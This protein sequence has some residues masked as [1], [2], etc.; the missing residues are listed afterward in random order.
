MRAKL[1]RSAREADIDVTMLKNI[2]V[3]HPV[4][5]P[6]FAIAESPVPNSETLWNAK[7]PRC[8]VSTLKPKSLAIL[9][10]D[11][12]SKEK[13]LRPYWTGFC[14]VIS[15][16]LLLPIGIDSPGS[17]S[18]LYDT[19]L[20]RTVGNSWFLTKQNI[21]HK[22]NSPRIF[23]P[24]CTSSVTDCP[25]SEATVMKSKKIRLLPTAEQRL[26]LRRWF[27]TARFTY[28]QTVHILNTT[29]TQANWKAIK[30]GILHDLPEWAKETPYQ[31]KS[32]AIR[33]A[34]IAVSAAKQKAKSTGQKQSVSFK[35]K[36]HPSDSIFIPKSAIKP[37]GV[38]HTKIGDLAMTEALPENIRDSRLVTDGDRYSLC[39]SYPVAIPKRKPNG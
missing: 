34:C 23:S 25:G 29:D 18:I 14:K 38:Y 5:L 19:S 32:V 6:L 10:A 13:G 20:N 12:T 33:D 11:S 4:Q 7:S 2:S 28:N 31:I 16:K 37:K 35:S 26:L 36:R 27:G 21:V 3:T 17:V 30:T 9:A 24:S 22:K 8:G 1:T 15:S 39:V